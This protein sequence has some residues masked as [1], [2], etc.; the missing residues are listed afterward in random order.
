M[1]KTNRH[2]R[3]KLE[4][5]LE[6][7][8]IF[9]YTLSDGRT[10]LCPYCGTPGASN[11]HAD[12]FTDRAL[13]HLLEKCPKAKGLQGH[14]MQPA[15][16]EEVVQADRL[17]KRFTSDASWRI[18]MSDGRWVCPYCTQPTKCR[19]TDKSGRMLPVDLIVHEIHGHLDTCYP[20]RRNPDK[21]HNQN[22]I[23]EIL[24]KRKQQDILTQQLTKLVQSNKVFQFA[25][26][27]GH[28]I[29]PFC[30]KPI[31]DVDFSTPFARAYSAPRLI[32]DHLQGGSCR[33]QGGAIDP[34]KTVEDMER[35]SAPFAGSGGEAKQQPS[36]PDPGDT[37]YIDL[38]RSELGELKQHLGKSQELR[39]NLQ[40]ARKAQYRMLPT[41]APDIPGYEIH[42][43][44]RASEEVS[45]DFYDFLV[46]EDGRVGV[47]MGDVSG[48]GVDAGLVMGM[49]KKTWVLRAQ[50]GEDPVTVTTKVN[51]D[52]LPEIDKTT[53]ITGVYGLLD[54][55]LHTFH[56][57]R[58]GHTF[59]I[60]Y[61]AATGYAQEVQSEGT[62][63][64]SMPEKM[65]TQKIEL[66]QIPLNPGDCVALFTDGIIEAMTEDGREFGTEMT[67]AAIT[68]HGA[69]DAQGVVEGLLGAI[70][71]FTQGFPQSDDETIL[72]I[73]RLQ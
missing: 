39:Q 63:L 58:C 50:T 36:S 49:A 8:S 32:L 65:F 35:I 1:G 40:R 25:D 11:R 15:Q 72:V 41:R 66:A 23:R 29:C 17:K 13:A 37:Q 60:F 26:R 14:T 10:W 54:P 48:H 53:F 5:L 4:E 45:G 51:N 30:E 59:P 9:N 18:K 28:W 46:M 19:L 6:S 56:F 55:E 24:N 47:I 57:V 61:Q 64:G 70:H 38:L 71:V 62:V 12:D 22:Q 42:P 52:I 34:G 67:L 33:F 43:Y 27:H 16:L 68:R 3:K 31:A 7:N 21:W 73:K 20:F 69:A 44:Y 2:L